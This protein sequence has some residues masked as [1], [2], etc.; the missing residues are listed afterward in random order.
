MLTKKLA[1]LAALCTIVPLAAGCGGG[2]SGSGST[3]PLQRELPAPV[4][5]TALSEHYVLVVFADSVGQKAMD[6]TL[7]VI[8]DANGTPLDVHEVR[9]DEQ[10]DRVIL[11]T[12]PQELVPYQLS[13][14]VVGETS[15]ALTFDGSNTP[16]PD[17][18][19]ATSLSNTT[20]L[21]TFNEKVEKVSAENRLFYRIS[22]PDLNVVS[23][24][25]QA[26]T[27]TVILTTEP[28]ENIEYTVVVTNVHRDPG[29]Q[30]IDPTNNRAAFFGI[31]PI[32]TV[33]PRLIAATATGKN[34]VVLRFSEPLDAPDVPGAA[35]ADDPINFSISPAL[36]IADTEI[37][38]FNT[39]IVLSTGDMQAGIDYTVTVGP[40]V[41]DPANNP[42][43]PAFNTAV[44]RFLAQPALQTAVAL[45]NTSVLLTFS[46]RLDQASAQTPGFYR[47]AA[48]DLA[49]TA[50]V[51]QV[52]Q[53]SVVL[54]TE[55]QANTQYTV[56]VTNV[57]GRL[58]GPTIDPER[59]SASFTGIPPFDDVAPRLLSAQATNST[60]V[61]LTFSEPLLSL[62]NPPDNAAED[63]SN[64]T[65]DPAVTVLSAQ[66][67]EAQTQVLLTTLPLAKGVP[68]L[69]TVASV[70]D[71][72]GNLIDPLNDSTSFTFLGQAGL[73][74]KDLP[75]VVGAAS[76]GN[77]GVVV[78]Y[79]RPMGDS[80]TNP[81]S[82]VVVQDDVNPEVGFL[83]IT[84]AAFT[85][86]DR[87]AVALTTL[88]Q[89]E[90]TYDLTAVNVQDFIGLPIAPKQIIAGVLLDPATAS[91]PGT[92]PSCAPLACTNGADGL[93]GDGLC[94]SD[95]D[96]T[97]TPPCT[98]GSCLG[99]C[100]SACTLQD[101]DGDGL[102]DNDEQR[103]W[104]VTITL[105]NGDT[106]R[107]EVTPDVTL[108]DTDGDGLEDGLEKNIGTDPRQ[109]DTDGD[110]LT[111]EEEYNSIYSDPTNQDSDGDDISD[112]LEVEFFKT[113]A[114]LEDSD[115]DGYS[116]SQELFEMSRDP[117]V[118]D[119]PRHEI[120][121]GG[122]RLQID[123]RFSYTDE[124]GDTHSET[125]STQTSLENDTSF[126]SSRLNQTV[127][128]FMAQVEGGID[129][130]QTD[131]ICSV[132]DRLKLIAT[133]G[134]GVEFTTANTVES[135]SAAMSAF[136][137]SLEKAREVSTSNAVSREVVGA[138]L[139]A[140]ITLQN[141]SDVAFRLSDLEI[142][143][144]TTDPQDPTLLVPVATLFPDST[145]AGNPVDYNVGPG[146]TRG[147]IIFSNRDVFPNLVE[148]LM[149]APRGLIFTVA[150]FNQTTEDG[151]NFAFGLQQVREHS[152]GV[153]ID[154]GDGEAREYHAITA[155]VLNRPRDELRCAASGDHPDYTCRDDGDCGTSAPC[156]GGSIVGG[157]SRFGG[158]GRPE[159]TRLDFI[160]QDVLHM[161]RST[162]ASLYAGPDL[163]A[164][165]VAAGDDV[166]V[167]AVGAPAAAPDAVV[168]AP[169]RNG[170]LD[171]AVLGDDFSSAVARIVAGPDGVADTAA[172][173]DD[174]QVVA[175]GELPLATDAVVIAPGANGKLDSAPANDDMIL[176]PDGILP[177]NDGAVQ[178]VAQGDDVQLVPVATTGV[179][180]DTIVITA[181]RNGVLD[182]PT[183]GDDRAAVVS[184][185]EVSKT[186]DANTPFAIL[187]GR[188][189]FS[190]TQAETGVCTV[191]SPPHFV[192]ESCSRTAS[193]PD[194]GCG[195]R[196][197]APT[198]TVFTTAA[199]G[200][201]S[202]GLDDATAF[203]SSGV[204]R[205]GSLETHYTS[206]AGNVL[207]IIPLAADAV[208]GTVVTLVTGRCTAD[209][210]NVPR[211][212]NAGA[213]DAVVVSPST[214]EFVS[215]VPGGDDVFVSPGISC[216][217]DA[218]CTVGADA[219]QCSGPQNVVR[220]DGRRNGQFRRFWA[221]L[222]PDDSQFQT[223]FGD[224]VVR[225]GDDVALSFIQDVDRDGLIAQ[226]EF[227][228]GSS[229]FKKDTDD[230][231][232]GD[233]SEVRLGWEVGVV[234]QPLRRVFPDPR[235]KD[236]DADGLSDRE[237]QDLRGAQC[238][239]LA[240]GPKSLLGSGSLLR[241]PGGF[242]TET[243]AQAC[244]TDDDCGGGAGTCID[245]VHCSALGMCPPCSDDVTLNR[246]DPR[247]R[248][249]DTDGV[250]DAGEVFG[251]L[252]GAGIVDPSSMD[253]ILAGANL[254]ADTRA[255]PANHCV[256]D[257][258]KHCM[259]DGDCLSRNCI[260]PVQCDEVQVVPFGAGVRDARTIVVAPGPLG[261]LITVPGGDD[262]IGNGNGLAESRVQGDDQ[263][264]VGP[265]QSLILGMQCVDGGNFEICS[266]IKPGPNGRIDS[267]RIG[268]DAV[269]PGGSGQ[270]LEVSDPL[271]PDTDMD[272]IADGNERILGSSPNLPGDAIFG[273][274]LDADGLTDVLEGLGW[275]VTVTDAVGA[276]SMRLVTS[277]PNLPDTDLDGLPDFAERNLCSS[278]PECPTDP[279]VVD[280]DGDG[281]SDYDE[282]SAEQFS[283]LARY[284]DFFPGFIVD[285]TGSKKY[286]TDP[287]KVDTDGDG[288]S[289][290]FELLVGW[291]VIRDDGSVQRVFS[292]PT[293]TDTDA[294]GLADGD[295]KTHGT[296]PGDADTD[297]DGRLDGLEVSIGTEPLQPDIF[298]SV[299]YSLLQLKGPQDGP[300]GQNDW[301]WRLSVQDSTERFPGR[302]LSTEQTD[303]PPTFNVFGFTIPSLFPAACLTNRFNLFLNRSTAVR[304]TPNNG[305]V[306]NGIVVEIYDINSDTQPID[307]VRVDKCR[308][309]FVDQPLTYDA[310]QAGTFMTRVFNLVDDNGNDC[311]GQVIA[312]ISV[313]C[314]GEGKGFCR[315]GNPCVADQD[316]ESGS[317][318]SCSGSG[319]SG[320]GTCQSECGN[321]LREFAPESLSP[322]EL[323]GCALTVA[324][325]SPISNCEACDD[326][327]TSNCG[328]CNAACGILGAQGPNTCPVGTPCIDSIDCT[329]SC[330]PLT[331][332]C[333]AVCGNGVVETGE[334]CDDGNTDACGPCNTTCSGAGSGTCAAMIGCN[335]NAVCTSAMCTG[336]VCQ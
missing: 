204:I 169:G 16:E 199:A 170:V 268:D 18:L 273:G 149:R 285:G 107:R 267:L 127:G 322:A 118:A 142:R 30:L 166:Q 219:G 330:D 222:L 177:G 288:L 235:F 70:K 124:N 321:G 237:E 249:T 147:P 231:G 51:L 179:P 234:G 10:N 20:V 277:D 163:I 7:Y 329:G 325:G 303:C 57:R 187:A 299:T 146:Q 246:T 276:V 270:K 125:S 100:T 85:G 247:V 319:C 33:K 295:E 313:N 49:V 158:T 99:A 171:S 102:T 238:A 83:T 29:N 23:A 211:G 278:P 140:E 184:G 292:D 47:I 11:V 255:C 165:S 264:V 174:I 266:A 284:N 335:A 110:Q 28:Q 139:S 283:A 207:T 183:R 248:D 6:T 271:N 26:D 13:G 1:V 331:G 91:F 281:I 298:V 195:V 191:A 324:A 66:L 75:R 286:G 176:G 12:D 68:Y 82:Y 262:V 52:D 88:S 206:K 161:R 221:L 203:P 164:T 155:G 137:S 56:V 167:V 126:S 305:I 27:T 312:E 291:I 119:L 36:A 4:D 112:N 87:T 282:L 307:E 104:V 218:D 60:T 209:T 245:A 182:T 84:G 232:L 318:S 92:P 336:G 54:T 42:I 32:D 185:Y 145:L 14:P 152:A 73:D 90:V 236:S 252:T 113:N 160:L 136:Q 242:G 79:S 301:R 61:L 189:L 332:T 230:D 243:G 320:V 304:L 106:I 40:N 275:N 178:S 114:I 220:V 151:R 186:C 205:V 269:I 15:S 95:D 311:S 111:D 224:I 274:D 201:M 279:E 316:C 154:F 229:D 77:T 74:D 120:I 25:R 227:L 188:N 254:R 59:N 193:N 55:P 172:A 38:V 258:T 67:N 228:R 35:R 213:A 314:I 65:I 208:G 123:E 116:D 41:H 109:V 153:S 259:T 46:E 128:N 251:Y 240:A 192:G 19:Y 250:S 323:V 214:A 260:H 287:T 294:D 256:E 253:V 181:G 81:G 48:P 121:V 293:L 138:S 133:I 334:T 194:A 226:Q 117:R 297:D 89:N 44:F 31:P 101:N 302:T 21:L 105:A 223:D 98:V 53:I 129:T 173:G 310:L 43:D 162:P 17:L 198:T 157:F 45:S 272:R 39:Q 37:N 86:P 200:A 93:D 76:T 257:N 108:R 131:T 141:L 168:V 22:L 58:G 3:P 96:C 210:Q 144:A 103:G 263:L 217:V 216:T 122:V 290:R 296:D 135:A 241:Q 308:M 175:V 132:L 289:D 180:E 78:Q 159:G 197:D 115:G 24:A 265:G 327:N 239:C 9:A 309:S 215:S 80:A 315:V 156:E 244:R 143:V 261:G 130:C 212:T 71:L 333:A 190:D 134:G 2:G 8:E 317:C 5:V 50:A 148:D 69:L 225:P 202:L 300:D 150:N 64:Y 328:T 306:L 62:S 196:A 280:T 233:F 97:A 63:A 326:G 34:T 72:A 94:A